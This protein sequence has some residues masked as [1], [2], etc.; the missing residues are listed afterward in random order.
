MAAVNIGHDVLMNRMSL[1][2][3][4]IHPAT[5]MGTAPE[6][7]ASPYYEGQMY[8]N[9]ITDHLYLGIGGT[10]GLSSRILLH[11]SNEV[12]AGEF[13]FAAGF[14]YTPTTKVTNLNADYVDGYHADQT[15]TA[16]TAAVRYTDGRLKVG[17]PIDSS[18]AVTKAYADAIGLGLSIR[19]PVIAATTGNVTISNC[20]ALQD[21]YTCVQGDRL[22]VKDQTTASENGIYTFGVVTGGYAPL[23]RATDADSTTELDAGTYVFIENGIVNEKR[24][25]VQQ[26]DNPIIGTSDITWKLFYQAAVAHAGNGL[27]ETGATFYVKVNSSDTYVTN[28]L[29]YADSSSTLNQIGIGATGQL[30][31]GN[32]AGS[33]PSWTTA[34]YPSTAAAGDLIYASVANNF[35]G[36]TIGSTYDVLKVATGLPTWGKIDNNNIG[37]SAAIA[38]SKLAT[39]TANRP[40]ITGADGYPTTEATLAL[41]RGGTGASL[42]DPNADRLLFW[43]DSAGAMTWLSLGG[44]LTISG[45]TIHTT[46]LLSYYKNYT[47]WAAH[48][49][50]HIEGYAHGNTGALVFTL[51]S[52]WTGQSVA[53][54]ILGW[55]YNTA[56]F[57]GII[58]GWVNT[59]HGYGWEPGKCSGYLIGTEQRVR[60]GKVSATGKPVIVIGETTDAATSEFI[61]IRNVYITGHSA[62]PVDP[63]NIVVSVMTDVSGITFW[64]SNEIFNMLSTAGPVSVGSGSTTR[65]GLNFY[66]DDNCGFYRSAAD[67]FHAITAGVARATFGATGNV[68]IGVTDPDAKLEV[69]GQVK[70]TGGTPGL[71]KV[72]TSDADG[73]ASWAAVTT[74]ADHGDLGG[75]ADDDH[76]QYALLL[77]RAGGQQLIGGIAAGDDLRFVTTSNATKGSYIFADVSAGACYIDAEENEL[78]T[79]SALALSRGGTGAVLTDPGADR[80]MFWDDSAGAMTWLTAGTG[81]TIDGTTITAN[82]SAIDHGSLDGL[83]GDDHAQYFNLLGRAGGQVA[84]GGTAAG[85]DLTFQTTSNA[86][87]GSYIFTELSAG[88]AYV[89][90]SHELLTE[91]TL[92]LARGGL[93]AALTDPG[94]DKALFWD[95]SAST[96]AWLGIGTCLTITGTTLEVSQSSIDHGSLNATS[97][98]HDDHTQYA[99]LAGRTGGQVLIGGTGVGDDLTFQTTSNATKGSYIF[100]ELSAGVAYVGASHDLLTETTLALARGGTGANLADPAAD[101]IM[102]WDESSN[103]VAWLTPGTGL[104]ITTTTIA[105]DPTVIDHHSLKDLSHDDHT[106]YALLVGRAGGQILKGGT[107][108]GDDLTL[109][110]TSNAT[111]GSYI[112]SELTAGVAYVGSS[113][114]LLTEATLAMSRGGTGAA[115]TDPAADKI[116]FWDDS[117]STTAW[118]A[119]G[120]GLAIVETNLEVDASEIGHGDLADLTDDTHP[121]YAMLAGRAG[122]QTL[123]GGTA[124]GDV[125]TLNS[126]SNATKGYVKIQPTSGYTAI[127]NITPTCA[128]TVRACP[129]EYTAANFAQAGGTI[130]CKVDV[131]NS[132][133]DANQGFRLYGGANGIYASYTALRSDGYVYWSSTTNATQTKD[134]RIGRGAAGVL[135]VYNPNTSA[136]ADI[137]CGS[138]G[139]GITSPTRP[140]SFANSVGEKIS[141]C[142]VSATARD[143]YGLAYETDLWV[144]QAPTNKGF[145]FYS[146]ADIVLD[147]AISEV[148]I[149]DYL[150]VGSLGSLEADALVKTNSSG[151]VS[152]TLDLPATI[153]I[154]TKVI[155]RK[156][157]TTVVGTG[158]TSSFTVTHNLGTQDIVVEVWEDS[159]DEAWIVGK[160]SGTT[161]AVVL[162][163]GYNVENAKVFN[164]VVV[165]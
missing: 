146:G 38:W 56:F 158:A 50:H 152:P 55:Q 31:K 113:H 57:S 119:I 149:P 3:V 102:F 136:Y 116:L 18:D 1:K 43:D 154:G 37:T 132:C 40:V 126:T 128:L 68:G 141:L 104:S 109:Q 70:I 9:T 135:S 105:V 110:T 54:E 91:A 80:V 45:T 59:S 139:V 53:M 106:Q 81:L 117:A 131:N 120:N 21:G 114:E 162:D 42:A 16:N 19:D 125:L 88:V 64:S 137:W 129:G 86:T 123:I 107:A 22:L 140:L 156:Y 6:E 97:L 7:V 5:G 82:A 134:L 93:G 67:T 164:V 96:V 148:T 35:T 33:A 69:N 23:T 155:A 122:G 150:T 76:T 58:K 44:N 101:R 108:A 13:N 111:K 51:P 66:G 100:S 133:F 25:Y 130:V 89:G 60:F 163:F 84:I 36:L 143:Y 103:L 138:I 165:G 32:G 26:T 27:G 75:L 145:A 160:D 94:V 159:T 121:Q 8:Y 153:T 127:G 63:T 28:A 62:T 98:T 95:D 142:S 15:V 77:G 83:E 39:G 92:A 24:S 118:L 29:L 147:V 99:L 115:L 90:S 151:R 11:D 87:K 49:W 74:L 2:Y 4:R 71:N 61:Y 65:A 73:L 78:K 34:A 48:G 46:G 30:L 161:N 72:L 14:T 52:E 12:I 20:A 144:A 41:S 157:T 85:D 17:T 47:G 10:T 79:E 112:F 124:S